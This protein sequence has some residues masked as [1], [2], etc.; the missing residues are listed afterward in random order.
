[1]D[2]A[3]WAF[4]PV[5]QPAAR[6]EEPRLT[7]TPIDPFIL[8][9]HKAKGLRPS[10]PASKETLIRRVTLDLVGLPPSPKEVDAFVSDTSPNA[11]E[12]LIDRLLASPHY[13]ERWGRHWLKY[14]QSFL[15]AP[16]FIV[17]LPNS[18]RTRASSS[19]PWR[20]GTP[21]RPPRRRRRRAG[22][23]PRPCG[24]HAGRADSRNFARTSVVKLPKV[25]RAACSC[26]AFT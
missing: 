16:D 22:C 24:R 15:A 19:P 1:M 4:Q 11:Y 14:Q 26:S 13:G 3:H 8:A 18:R 23:A 12:K 2:R 10:A 7:K 6:S 9:A 20:A 5:R 21:P 25:S 17:L